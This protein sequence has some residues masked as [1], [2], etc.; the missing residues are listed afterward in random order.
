[1]VFWVYTMFS[2]FHESA[3]F[4]IW[5]LCIIAYQTFP[6]VW[7]TLKKNSDTKY[8]AKKYLI[9]IPYKK[10]KNFLSF[11]NSVPWKYKNFVWINIKLN[12]SCNFVYNFDRHLTSIRGYHS[13]VSYGVLEWL[14]SLP[15][16]TDLCYPCT[17]GWLSILHLAAQF[18]VKI[19]I[20]IIQIN[21]CFHTWFMHF[22]HF[23]LFV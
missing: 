17:T 10:C 11:W 7:I 4:L 15:S 6:F 14:T 18:S 16:R 20:A 21:A 23:P 3:N 13:C 12:L 22:Q 19:I 5:Y 9:Y 1:M 8:I 2:N